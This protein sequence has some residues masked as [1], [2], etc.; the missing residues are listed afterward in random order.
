M[1]L[2]G[3]SKI[4]KTHSLPE[5]QDGEGIRPRA[6]FTELSLSCVNVLYSESVRLWELALSFLV[7]KTGVIVEHT[8]QDWYYFGAKVVAV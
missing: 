7:C 8:S 3:F 4:L 5:P 1:V 6:S 2:A